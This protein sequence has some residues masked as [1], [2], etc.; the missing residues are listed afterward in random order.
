MPKTTATDIFN[1]VLDLQKTVIEINEKMTKLYDE[2]AN[3]RR[4]VNGVGKLVQS[5]VDSKSNTNVTSA[6]SPPPGRRERTRTVSNNSVVSLASNSSS[7]DVDVDVVKTKHGK[8]N[9]KTYNEYPCKPARGDIWLTALIDGWVL[10]GNTFDIRDLIKAHKGL[11]CKPLKGWVFTD[12]H[13]VSRVVKRI[14]VEVKVE[15]I[16]N[17]LE[18]VGYV[19]YVP[20]KDIKNPKVLNEGSST[21]NRAVLDLLD[22]SG[23]G[24]QNNDGRATT[25]C[26][27]EESS[28]EEDGSDEGGYSNVDVSEDEE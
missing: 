26:V 10:H 27:I 1:V 11:F 2:N 5:L 16:K 24:S 23:G 20:D 28:D 19:P 18:G 15:Q 8:K 22:S 6:I 12:K 4:R 17:T 21:Q 14:S 9:N 3:L 7:D 25:G 13:A